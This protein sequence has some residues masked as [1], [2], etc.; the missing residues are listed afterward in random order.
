MIETKLRALRSQLNPH[1]IFNCITSIKN[2]IQKKDLRSAESFLHLFSKFLRDILEQSF[3]KS[4]SIERE[5]VFCKRYLELESIRLR[6]LEYKIEIDKQLDPSFYEVPPLILQPILENSIEHGLI[7]K[8][9]GGK[10]I[11]IFV[12][13]N[14]EGILFRI[15]DNGVGMNYRKSKKKNLIKSF[16]E[17][18]SY[19]LKITQE[20]LA[21]VNGNLKIIDRSTEGKNLQGTAVE[22]LF[23]Y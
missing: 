16:K 10:H 19:G 13:N 5:L 14:S 15:E 2:L 17:K 22:L 18:K 6:L 3:E 20:R 9:S 21:M 8:K 23:K 1:F 7:P 4:I 12:S 11:N